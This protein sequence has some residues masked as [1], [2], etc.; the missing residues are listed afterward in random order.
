MNYKL[1]LLYKKLLILAVVFGPIVWLM[2]TED[3]QRRTDTAVLWLFGEAEIKMELSALD[4][5]FTEDELREV[6]PDLKWQCQERATPYGDY[7]CVSRI[8]V[9]NGIPSKYITFFFDAGQL[10]A[11]KLHYRNSNHTQLLSLLHQQLGQAD[12][13]TRTSVTAPDP[14]EVLQWRT[15]YGLVVMKRQLKEDEEPSLFWIA[16]NHLGR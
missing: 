8:G 11:L 7:L 9:F 14:D 13:E 3:G 15:A 10:S 2:F 4:T 1:P 16:S 6:Y 5:Q 12:N